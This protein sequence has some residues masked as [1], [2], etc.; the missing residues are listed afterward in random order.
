MKYEKNLFNFQKFWFLGIAAEK[1]EAKQ[2]KDEAEKYKKLR[3]DYSNSRV[4]LMLFRLFYNEKE[5]EDL[6][7]ETLVSK[8]ENILL[9]NYLL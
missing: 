9:Q 1:K 7:D 5:T 3:E 8:K 2:E 4:F 6:R